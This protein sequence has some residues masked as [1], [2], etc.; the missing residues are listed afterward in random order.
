MIAIDRVTGWLDDRVAL[1][2][3]VE[4]SD[5]GSSILFYHDG[6]CNL[7]FRNVTNVVTECRTRMS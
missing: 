6:D 5:R 3:V 2:E 1:L 7:F 4:E